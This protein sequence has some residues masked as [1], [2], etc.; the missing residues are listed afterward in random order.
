MQPIQADR[1]SLNRV[2]GRRQLLL[3]SPG[4]DAASNGAGAASAASAAAGATV[5]ASMLSI[6]TPA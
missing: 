6:S 1:A 3:F 5:M 2:V 4:A